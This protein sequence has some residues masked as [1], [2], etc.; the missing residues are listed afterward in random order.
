MKNRIRVVALVGAGVLLVGA[1]I[2]LNMHF[3]SV[4]VARVIFFGVPISSLVLGRFLNGKA[5]H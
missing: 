2:L 4:D 3:I 1:A 5:T